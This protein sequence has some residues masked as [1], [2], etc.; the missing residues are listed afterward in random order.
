MAASACAPADR[1]VQAEQIRAEIQGLPGVDSVDVGYINDFENGA[2]L[3]VEVRVPRAT[4][5][6]IA[7]VA[8]RIRMLKG[9]DFSRHRQETDFVV[10]DGAV[11]KRRSD[12]DLQQVAADTVVL[13]RLRADVP[14]GSLV[15]SRDENNSRLEVRDTR[16][17]DTALGTVLRALAGEVGSIY[18]RSS[19]PD[20]ESSWDV[21][22]PLSAERQHTI[23]ALRDTLP[24]T[25]YEVTVRDRRIAG[26]SVGLGA[27]ANAYQNAVTMLTALVPTPTHSVQVQW[28]LADGK[29][30]E[31]AE[32]TACA[33]PSGIQ[34]ELHDF[35]GLRA[36]FDTHFGRCTP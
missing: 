12:V 8:D 36:Y 16:D 18:T 2:N 20:T 30:G 28:R 13:R 1:S 10:G 29:P 15:W 5:H 34:P 3:N 17:S 26:L 24:V 33:A 19:Q 31:V 7:E 35:Y 9:A 32:F 22:L 11:I 23:V 14:N 6:Q 21:T 4:E 27:P 25:V